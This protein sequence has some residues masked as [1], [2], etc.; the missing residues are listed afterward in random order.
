M[1]ILMVT[2]APAGSRLGNRVTANRWARLLRSLG[3]DVRV[4]VD[5][6]TGPADLCIALHARRSAR[7]AAAYR[8]A[9]PRGPLIVALTGTDLYHDLPHSRP[10]IRSLDAADRIV[11]LQS[12]AVRL[13]K[14]QW[15]A[16]TEVIYQS[17][18][19]PNVTVSPLRRVF[20]IAVVAHLR[21]VKDPLRTA[22]A[23]RLL[24]QESRIRITH[25]GAV[26]EPPF[27]PRVHREMQ[28]NPRF[29]WLGDRPHWQ[30]W[31][32]LM[33]SRALVVS[34]AMEGGANVIAEAIAAGTPVLASRVSGNI[35]MLDAEYPG[36]FGYRKTDELAE[37]L[38]RLERDDTFRNELTQ[39]CRRLRPRFSPAREKAAWRSLLRQFTK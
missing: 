19:P 6:V 5:E 2:P 3:H 39:W 38:V 12:E 23:A 20:E 4:T 21:T 33:R 22:L 30:V 17:A 31:R 9:H 28:R 18:K 10:A 37:L 11:A 13:L 29:H 34:S 32:Y 24:S 8:R 1:K 7:A 35:G 16:K 15:R 36:Y 14:P 25:V 26:L 27:E